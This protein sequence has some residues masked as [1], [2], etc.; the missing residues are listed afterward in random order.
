MFKNT[1]G[2]VV[3]LLIA[4]GLAWLNMLAF[5]LLDVGTPQ[6]DQPAQSSVLLLLLSGPQAFAP[7]IA[8]FVVRKWVTR[9]GFADAGL[10]L[11]LRRGWPYYLI[12]LL[13]PL[14]V[15]PIAVALWVLVGGG[16]P[17]WSALPLSTLLSLPLMALSM[18]LPLFGEE[19]GWRGYLQL[20]LAPGRPL[21]AAVGTGLIWA[22]WHY[23]MLLLML[24][25]AEYGSALLLH[26]I[27]AILS[28]IF[29]GWLKDRSQSVWPACLAHGAQNFIVYMALSLLMADL[30]FTLGRL[31]YGGVGFAVV[32]L[33]VL[34]VGR[35]GV[36]EPQPAEQASG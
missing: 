19:F 17:D 22:V 7:A 26:P 13:F 36:Q 25:A 11:Y 16:Q 10:R 30:P 5:W 9:E 12:A 34:T 20:R 21:L 23:P 6:G 32:A 14:V 4:C 24:P 8:A 35:F 2:I 29:Y 3:F 27:T 18:A 28:S 31:G 1:R 15:I 33:L